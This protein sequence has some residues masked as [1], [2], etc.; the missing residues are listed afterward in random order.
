MFAAVQRA[1]AE[2][3]QPHERRLCAQLDHDEADEQHR[4]EHERPDRL[5][6]RPALLLRLH[7][8]VDERHQPAGDGDG[9]GDV[10]APVRQLVLRLRD[11]AQRGEEHGDSD[12]DVDEEDPRP[13][14]V[15]GQRAAEDQADRAAADRDRGPDAERLRPLGPFGERGRDDRE[16]GRRDERRAEPLQAARA[17]QHS[18]ARREPVQQRRGREDDE[19]EQ[20]Q[21]LPAEQVARAAAQ[22]QEPAE[23]ERVGVD[24]PL[25]V[26]LGKAQV[27]L[28]RRE[29]DVHD[30]PV[31]HDH[32]LGKADENEDQPGVRRATRHRYSFGKRTAQSV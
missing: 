13:G 10:E 5:G 18:G 1:G 31:E 16:G 30:G 22:E 15:L 6:G 20:E 24:D 11:V 26:R 21:P 8:R 25:E 2:D 4:G 12:R 29:R 23:D 3:G 17:D 14:E 7:D 32:E 27:L 9:A 19:T 28:D